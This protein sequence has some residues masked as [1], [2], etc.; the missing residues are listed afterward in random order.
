MQILEHLGLALGLAS[1]AG[2]N[3]YLTTLLAGLAVR[4]NLLHLGEQHADLAILAHPWVLGVA[5]VLYLV[6]FFA[7]KIPWLD[8][9]WDA[10]HTLIR[11]VGGC[12]LALQTLG[13]T[14]PELQVIAG[15]LA[16]GAAL[17]THSAKAGTRLLANHS[18]EPVSN[19]ALSLGEDAAVVGGSALALIFPI[20]A[21][22]FFAIVL[23]VIWIM[24]PRI[25]RVLR[26]SWDI[27]RSRWRAWSMATPSG[28]TS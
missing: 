25:F 21:F 17:T 2:V 7:D 3:L 10:I 15:L 16:G 19:I 1:L 6:E 13:H 20:V 27:I 4:F 14:A 23:T 12:L 9:L 22:V 28:G 8:S 11:P 18:P 26:K 24:L 5:G